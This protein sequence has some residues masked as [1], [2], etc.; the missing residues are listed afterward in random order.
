MFE[1]FGE[2]ALN[3]LVRRDGLDKSRRA[4]ILARP[5]TAEQVLG[6]WFPGE[7][8]ERRT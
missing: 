8:P 6:E 2:F 3:D 5:Y 4:E 1:K 7:P